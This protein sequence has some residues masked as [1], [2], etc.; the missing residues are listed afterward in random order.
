[1]RVCTGVS[2]CKYLRLYCV[3]KTENRAIKL[4]SKLTYLGHLQPR[5]QEGPP[6]VFSF[7]GTKKSAQ[8]RP[9]E[10]NFRRLGPK[11]ATADSTR[12]R[13]AGGRSGAPGESF[14]ARRSA[15]PPRQRLYPLLAPSSSSSPRFPRRINAKTAA[16]CR[17]GQPPLMPHGRRVPRPPRNHATHNAPA[18]PTTRRL[19]L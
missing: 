17:A 2:V 9:Q 11:L 5:P 8:S 10:P 14:L 16:R 12:T 18:K 19:R 4:A 1:M 13:R 3:K 15:G 7:A 6:G